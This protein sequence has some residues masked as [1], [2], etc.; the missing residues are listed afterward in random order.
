M[1][2]VIVEDE[3]RIREGIT[4]LLE[5]INPAYE[6]V[7][8]A[9]DGMDGLALIERTQPDLVITDIR[10]PGMDGLEL[11]DQ[12]HEK[13]MRFKAI[14]VSAYSEFAYAR[15]AIS[16]GVSE[17]LVKP[18]S[19][20]DFSASIRKIEAQIAH[21]RAMGKE[22]PQQLHSLENIVNGILFSGMP[23]DGKLRE[24]IGSTYT[25]DPNGSF[26]AGIVYLGE[27]YKQGGTAIRGVLKPL[28]TEA[29][30]LCPVFELPAN[31]E[32][33]LIF[34]DI[35][36]M[37]K[38]E[39]HYK[40][41]VVPAVKAV[42]KE[43]M[44]FGWTAFDGIGWLREGVEILRRHMDWNIA[45]GHAEVISY[46]EILQVCTMPFSY[47]IDIE[48]RAKAF[49]CDVNYTGM[50]ETLMLLVRHLQSGAYKPS[51]IKETAVQ[52][53]WA[54]LNILKEINFEA[55]SCINQQCLLER[56]MSAKTW[57]ELS[58][59]ILLLPDAISGEQDVKPLSMQVRRAMNYISEYYDTRITLDEIAAKIGITPEYLG[60]QFHKEVGENFN[61]YIKNYRIGKAKKLLIGTEM[62]LLEISSAVGYSD[63]K[64][65][66]RVFREATGQIPAE[67]RKTHK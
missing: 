43:P 57:E 29:F 12:L 46:P 26:A 52:F 23:V 55:Y 54:I 53:L 7:G 58:G 63:S 64:Y 25:I 3:S 60:T 67:Y 20:D 33:L 1:R 24:F 56:I 11:L 39:A 48:K 42:W 10:M 36:D 32:L 35:S 13:G 9:C 27:K 4:R 17:Y 37:K 5:K 34:H 15:Q 14:V 16:L 62:K 22:K 44:A 28:E 41:A 51:E 21:E 50:R 30:C 45:E 38:A 66:S 40:A 31:N 49:I 6:V 2:I 18:V 8:T 61:L 47:P 59:S 19:L 65:F